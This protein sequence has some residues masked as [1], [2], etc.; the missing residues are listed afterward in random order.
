M[1]AKE[2]TH[3]KTRALASQKSETVSPK[4]KPHVQK[5]RQEAKQRKDKTFEEKREKLQKETQE[6]MYSQSSRFSS[7]SRSLIFGIIGTIWVITY[8]DGHMRIPNWALLFGLLAGLLFL[9]SDVI[10]YYSDSVSYEKEQN[11]FDDYKTQEDLDNKHEPI[12]DRINK[13]SH[14]FINTK[15]VILIIC[16]IL[17]IVGLCI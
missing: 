9:F 3:S 2:Q 11:Q 12:M 17:F 8:S 14:I 6:Y 10:H 7:V 1:T 5:D 15:F 4:T 13:R 16:S